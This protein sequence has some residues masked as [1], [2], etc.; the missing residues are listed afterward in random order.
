M[1]L[2]GRGGRTPPNRGGR[3]PTNL[4]GQG[5]HVGERASP[6]TNSP[7]S[8]THPTTMESTCPTY[9]GRPLPNVGESC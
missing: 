8:S 7:I 5:V 3:I 4:G 2:R 6:N 1:T 9:E